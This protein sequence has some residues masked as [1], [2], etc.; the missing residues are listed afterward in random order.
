MDKWGQAG[1]S[2]KG[3]FK[4]G[5]GWPGADRINPTDTL[6]EGKTPTLKRE[7]CCPHNSQGHTTCTVWLSQRVAEAEMALETHEHLESPQEA[8]II[9]KRSLNGRQVNML[10]LKRGIQSSQ[11][12]RRHMK[13]RYDLLTQSSWSRRKSMEGC[14]VARTELW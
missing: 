6:D 4:V 3:R 12:W 5:Q 11:I 10:G 2:R 8:A 1:Y 9:E 14:G 7:E 13:T